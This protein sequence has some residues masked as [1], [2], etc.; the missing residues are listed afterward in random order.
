[1]ANDLEK[2]QRAR[3]AKA[4]DPY[5]FFADDAEAEVYEDVL[6]LRRSVEREN[7]P[8]RARRRG[9]RLRGRMY[10]PRDS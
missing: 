8:M 3:F 9:P 1:M 5:L 6:S 10:D 7:E 2:A 4:K